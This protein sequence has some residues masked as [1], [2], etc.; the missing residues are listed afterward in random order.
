MNHLL[1]AAPGINN[2]EIITAPLTSL[3]INT[4]RTYFQTT[5]IRCTWHFYLKVILKAFSYWVHSIDKN[6]SEHECNFIMYC[7][8]SQRTGLVSDY[9][10]TT[11]V[12][13]KMISK[14]SNMHGPFH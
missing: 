5:K 4:L 13:I 14:F 6:I 10:S 9:R 12:Y 8:K 7:R 1:T 2:V 3:V 11:K